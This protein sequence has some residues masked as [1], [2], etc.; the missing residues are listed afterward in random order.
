MATVAFRLR[1]RTPLLLVLLLGLTAGR[2]HAA[3]VQLVAGGDYVS[4]APDQSTRDVLLG[5]IAQLGGFEAML[6]GLRFDDRRIGAGNGVTAGLGFPV[7][8]L[9]SLQLQASRF[10]G[11]GDYRAWRTRVGPRLGL[12]GGS[13]AW[14]AWGHD[15]AS[16]SRWDGGVLEATAPLFAGLSLRANAAA[17]RTSEEVVSAA[18]S[19]GIAWTG[20]HHLELIGEVGR[21][22]NG[23]G[24]TTTPG[25][26]A[27]LG[28]LG[29]GPG[30]SQPNPDVITTTVLFGARVSLP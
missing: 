12:A 4:T 1:T 19:G 14:I 24:M 26:P 18:G 5:G 3:P 7:A 10:V 21:A 17:G 27:L 28:L 29:G 22:R 30:S 2:L 25:P 13:A 20:F 8:P 11:D 23:G 16:G 6:V 9:T 15:E